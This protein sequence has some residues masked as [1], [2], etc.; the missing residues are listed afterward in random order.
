[1]NLTHVKI[2]LLR[3][4]SGRMKNIKI[5]HN[6]ST[7]VTMEHIVSNVMPILI[8]MTKEIETRIKSLCDKEPVDYAM[9]QTVMDGHVLWVQCVEQCKAVV[10]QAV[11]PPSSG[12]KIAV[13][14]TSS[15]QP[16][17]KKPSSGSSS[18]KQQPPKEKPSSSS[19]S[20]KQPSK[21]KKQKSKYVPPRVG[22]QFQVS[23][24]PETGETHPSPP[25]PEKRPQHFNPTSEMRSA[26][27]AHKR[28]HNA[29]V[30]V[31]KRDTKSDTDKKQ[32]EQRAS[33][34]AKKIEQRVRQMSPGSSG[35][36][37]FTSR[38]Q[39]SHVT[40]EQAEDLFQLNVNGIT[41]A[42]SIV[43]RGTRIQLAPDTLDIVMGRGGALFVGT[44]A[45]FTAWIMIQS[46]AICWDL[47]RR[48]NISPE[49]C[50]PS[51]LRPRMANGAFDNKLGIFE[52]TLNYIA[53]YTRFDMMD[54]KPGFLSHC[55]IVDLQKSGVFAC[56]LI[57]EMTPQKLIRLIESFDREFVPGG[58][59][60]ELFSVWDGFKIGQYD[61][62]DCHSTFSGVE[63]ARAAGSNAECW[64]EVNKTIPTGGTAF[65]TV[66]DDSQTLQT[67]DQC[68]IMIQGLIEGR[69]PR[70]IGMKVL[71]WYPECGKVLLKKHSP[72]PPKNP[73]DACLHPAFVT[74]IGTNY[75]EIELDGDNGKKTTEHPARI[76]IHPEEGKYGE[77]TKFQREVFNSLP[78]TYLTFDHRK[79]TAVRQNAISLLAQMG[80]RFFQCRKRLD[81]ILKCTD[82]K[83]E[84]RQ[85]VIYGGNNTLG[86][87]EEV[88][89]MLKCFETIIEK[90]FMCIEFTRWHRV[91]EQHM[92]STS[93]EFECVCN[94]MKT[95]IE[96]FYAH[97]WLA[98]RIDIHGKGVERG[99]QS[100]LKFAKILLSVYRRM[101]DLTMLISRKDI[102]SPYSLIWYRHERKGEWNQLITLPMMTM[103]KN[104][105]IVVYNIRE[106]K[107]DLLRGVKITDLKR[108]TSILFEE[109]R[110]KNCWS[111]GTEHLLVESDEKLAPVNL[112]HYLTD[113]E[114]ETFLKDGPDLQSIFQR[115]GFKIYCTT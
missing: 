36:D 56:G 106:K 83:L 82:K 53:Q 39:A 91:D 23:T 87:M 29:H 50:W 102:P 34:R 113:D 72:S 63:G 35:R 76:F 75:I 33:K 14:P 81:V 93:L 103:F 57:D 20:S 78:N 77:Q 54:F 86:W 40:V 98:E 45:T 15:K 84:S 115:C 31:P 16:P 104:D 110:T 10:S 27:E 51:E 71:V 107:K 99:I 48:T 9:L 21:K 43:P 79:Q 61:E 101:K 88:D 19:G 37:V 112:N 42:K 114:I 89:Y 52:A 60:D 17:K 55:S 11:T 74:K 1:M 62:S 12:S 109:D 95:A 41:Q 59:V 65:I 69:F 90:S 2:N 28:K 108:M 70:R 30:T 47:P 22:T 7:A 25:P 64:L 4:L 38:K 3:I 26:Y 85:P 92:M 105:G 58:N 5:R 13:P 44:I 73:E 97:P 24:L 111:Y 96:M 80:L 49:S 66:S 6:I 18:S 94:D 67:F 32:L 46:R 100:D 8:K 68:Y